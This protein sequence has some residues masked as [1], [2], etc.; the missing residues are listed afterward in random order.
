M[1][2]FIRSGPIR[3]EISPERLVVIP[4]GR[5]SLD[6]YVTNRDEMTVDFDL[7]VT[8]MPAPWA[9]APTPLMG[10]KPGEQHVARLVVN[11]PSFPAG[12]PGHYAAVVRAERRGEPRGSRRSRSR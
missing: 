1:A 6:V 5:G 9:G 10:I 4:G 8:G 7:S 11:V 12:R 2:A 3:L